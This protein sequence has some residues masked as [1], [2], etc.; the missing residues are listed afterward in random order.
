MHEEQ[1]YMLTLLIKIVIQ[2][3]FKASIAVKYQNRGGKGK[4]LGEKNGDI[5]FLKVQ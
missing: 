1:H 3:I 5:F 4:K 2:A